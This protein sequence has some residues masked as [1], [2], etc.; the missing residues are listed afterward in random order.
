MTEISSKNTDVLVRNALKEVENGETKIGYK[1]DDILAVYNMGYNR[2]QQ[3]QPTQVLE[4]Q[5]SAFKRRFDGR[6]LNICGHNWTIRIVPEDHP[7]MVASGGNGIC[8]SYERTLY[9]CDLSVSDDPKLYNNIEGFLCKVLRH[10][11]VHAVFFELCHPEYYEDEKL[12][13]ILA[14]AMPIL[15]KVMNSLGLLDEY[16]K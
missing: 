16:V 3:S 11:I 8:E 7:K 6:V 9:V 15:G 4:E 10:E 14:F 5:G 13:D 12:T 2:G 1:S